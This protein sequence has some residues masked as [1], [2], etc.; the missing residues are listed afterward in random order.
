[1]SLVVNAVQKNYIEDYTCLDGGAV[2]VSP[3]AMEPTPDKRIVRRL[4]EY[5]PTLKVHWEWGHNRWFLSVPHKV[6]SA[7]RERVLTVCEQDGSYRP[8]DERVMVQLMLADSYRYNDINHFKKL[9]EENKRAVDQKQA[10]DLGN[11]FRERNDLLYRSYFGSASV[12]PAGGWKEF[13]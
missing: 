4:K 1:M 8:L 12:A 6:Y 3:A 9:I 5:D 13:N 10:R 2:K 7:V 11:L